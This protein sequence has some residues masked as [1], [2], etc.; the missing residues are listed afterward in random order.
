MKNYNMKI[1]S[2]FIPA[3]FAIAFF[4]AHSPSLFVS[5]V[6]PTKSKSLSVTST[7]TPDAKDDEAASPSAT[8]NDDV[9]NKLRQIETLKD[10]IAT[11]VAQLR[12]Q[13]KTAISGVIKEIQAD[14]KNIILSTKKEERVIAYDDDTLVYKLSSGTKSEFSVTKLAKDVAIS[15]FGYNNE[16]KSILSAKYIYQK[17]VPFIRIVGKIADIDKQ[18]YTITIHTKEGNMLVDIESYSKITSFPAL[19]KAGVKI[20]FSKLTIGDMTHILATA[21]PKEDNRFSAQQLIVL[22]PPALIS[23]ATPPATTDSPT[24]STPSATTKPKPTGKSPSP[25]PSL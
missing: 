22:P 24:V 21:N 11:K 25:T 2:F 16:D 23:T 4:F 20:G 14:K 12:E 6:S 5:A 15:V 17:Q 19:G 3:V 18:N 10:K 8:G 7:P 1:R 9:I 13:D